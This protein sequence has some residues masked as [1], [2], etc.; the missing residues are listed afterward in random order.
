[1][2]EETPLK[3]TALFSLMPIL[4]ACIPESYVIIF[5]QRALPLSFL[6]AQLLCF[7]VFLKGEICPGQRGRLM[8]AQ[9]FFALYWVIIGIIGLL[10]DTRPLTTLALCFCGAL[11]VIIAL[12][13]PTQEE[14]R[15]DTWLLAGGMIGLIAI[16]LY[17]LLMV[18]NRAPYLIYS[19]FAQLFIGVVLANLALVISR[20]RLQ[21]LIALLPLIMAVLLVL[22]I[23]SVLLFMAWNPSAVR[24]AN[25]F[26]VVLYFLSHLALMGIL[27]VTIFRKIKLNYP[28]LMLL[29]FIASFLPIW[30]MLA[31]F[32]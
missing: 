26:A 11:M 27:A 32:I 10:N 18:E 31:Y 24:F 17:V 1:M 22:N 14:D 9:G 30:A 6:A 3:R 8:V 25:D 15:R 7:V 23:L 2:L 21:G 5:Q 16:V 29:L 28:A 4:L 12:K 13:Q 19:P 20:N